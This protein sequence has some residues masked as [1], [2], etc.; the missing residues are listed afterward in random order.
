MKSRYLIPFL[1]CICVL[2]LS[3]YVLLTEVYGDRRLPVLL[4]AAGALM[5]SILFFWRYYRKFRKGSP[6]KA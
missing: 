6:V 1:G 5:S 2:I 3:E 4:A